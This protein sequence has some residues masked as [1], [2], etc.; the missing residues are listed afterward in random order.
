MERIARNTI[1]SPAIEP[2]LDHHRTV[3][4]FKRSD[5]FNAL[6][7]ITDKTSLKAD[8]EDWGGGHPLLTLAPLT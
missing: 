3:C 7:R 1:D 4:N 6:W 5:N 2:R 8:R